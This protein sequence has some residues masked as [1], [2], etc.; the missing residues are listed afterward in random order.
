M[1][2]DSPLV[3]ESPPPQEGDVCPIF[4]EPDPAALAATVA[5]EPRAWRTALGR[6]AVLGAGLTALS[7][8]TAVLLWFVYRPHM[9]IDWTEAFLSGFATWYPWMLLGPGVFFLARRFRLEPG[10]WAP[11][12]A[13][14]APAAL[15][16]GVSHGLIRVA[17]GPWVDS[18]PVPPDRIV[19]GQLLLT[20]VS[21]W[22]FVGM[23]QAWHNYRRYREREV[24]S[25]RLESQLARA[26]LEVLRMQLH[27]HFLFNTLHAVSALLHRDPAAADEMIAQLSDLLRMTLDNFGVQEVTLAEELEFIRRYLDIQQTRFQDR[28]SVT[29]DVPAETLDARVPNQALQPIVENAIKHGLDGRQGA[30]RIELRARGRAS[31]LQLTV[32]D[33]GPGVKGGPSAPSHGGIGL[34]NTRARLEQLYGPLA[35]LDL[36]AHPEGGTIVTLLIPQP[37]PLAPRRRAGETP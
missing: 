14:H 10:R 30:G 21:Y 24:R 33:D 29:I 27:P 11:A 37:R 36:S 32:R 9:P 22:V 7:L 18:R 34:S 2:V 8:F 3:L 26:Q 17:V 6:L 35:A 13:V 25:S 31:M 16:F 20:F 1:D 23:D 28:L 4:D 12:L 19:L 5:E 15:A